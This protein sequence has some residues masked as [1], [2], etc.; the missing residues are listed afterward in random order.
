MGETG[1]HF[2]ILLLTYSRKCDRTKEVRLNSIP[3]CELN[4]GR[5]MDDMT[6]Q[7][8]WNKDNSS[9]LQH[10]KTSPFISKSSET[11]PDFDDTAKS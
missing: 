1:E 2:L 10:D 5:Q 7:P 3:P 11:S 9:S 8:D 4:N 6:A